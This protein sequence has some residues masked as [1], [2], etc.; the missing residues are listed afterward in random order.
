MMAGLFS[1]I[2]P[3][4]HGR[5]NRRIKELERTLLDKEA[6]LEAAIRVNEIKETQ[7]EAFAEVI[8]RDRERVRAE[9][10]EASR[11]LAGSG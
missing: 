10:A 8:V 9:T 7:I 6:E 11:K 4:K 2:W 3:R 5:L 1:R